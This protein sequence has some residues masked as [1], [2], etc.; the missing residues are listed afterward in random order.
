MLKILL[1]LTLVFVSSSLFATTY[2]QVSNSQ[3]TSTLKNELDKWVQPDEPGCS[4]AYGNKHGT[5]YY[6]KGLVAFGQKQELTQNTQFLNASISKQF[7]AHAAIKLAQQGKLNLKS[8]IRTILTEFNKKHPVS[9]EQLMNHTSGVADH[10]MLFE[11]QGKSLEDHYSQSQAY[12]LA[13]QS[14]YLEFTP[15]SQFHYSNGGYV[16]LAQ[17][18][19]KITG[20]NLNKNINQL[21]LNDLDI[22]ASY[23]VDSIKDDV[24][25][26]SG[27]INIKNNFKPLKYNS[28][29]YGGGNLIISA[30]GFSRW[31]NYLLNELQQNKY[32]IDAIKNAAMHNHYYAGLYVDTDDKGRKMIHHG[33]Y[34]EHTSQSIVFLPESNEFAL[35]LCNRS[36]FRPANITRNI[37]RKLGSLSLSDD[38]QKVVANTKQQV[39]TPGLYYSPS[40]KKSALIFQEKGDIYYYGSGVGSPKKLFATSPTGWHT[41]LSAKTVFVS[42]VDAKSVKVSDPQFS[43]VLQRIYLVSSPFKEVSKI[44]IFHNELVGDIEFTFGNSPMINFIKSVGEIALQCTKEKICFSEEGFVMVDAYDEK[45]LVVST[46]DIQNLIFQ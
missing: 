37:L 1:M 19:E 38:I 24:D 11:L 42:A 25:Y 44:S 17:L 26:A 15:G 33:G 35:A 9:T 22:S 20:K 14:D 7:T 28:Y 39:L 45:K 10:W 29:I 40:E 18:L 8:D 41:K 36:D 3:V 23:L 30:T 31:A 5:H 21:F 2:I 43:I 34:Y 12:A 16:V 13:T 4:I 32:Y 6:S 46:H 27:H